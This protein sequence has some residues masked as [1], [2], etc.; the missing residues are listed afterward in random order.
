M[1][2][3]QSILYPCLLLMLSSRTF[4]E[5]VDDV[6]LTR[7]MKKLESHLDLK[8]FVIPAKYHR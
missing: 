2:I 4:T 1:I 3:T 6:I 7:E 8:D 5:L